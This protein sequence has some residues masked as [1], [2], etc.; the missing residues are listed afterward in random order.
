M[1]NSALNRRAETAVRSWFASSPASRR[2]RGMPLCG[3]LAALVFLPGTVMAQRF[4]VATFAVPPGWTQQEVGDALLFEMR[5]PGT[6]AFC[7]IFVRKSRKAAASLSQ[8]LDR[9]WAEWHARQAVTAETPDP[10]QLDLPGGLRLAQR[11]G[12]LQTGSGTMLTM[13]N[14]FQKADR[15]VGVVVNMSD[16]QAHER[17]SAAVGDFLAS[18]RIDTTQAASPPATSAGTTNPTGSVT[19]R[20]DPALA[21]K[22]GNSVVGT[23]RYAFGTVNVTL[24]APTQ[25]RHAIDVRF[26]SN[27]TYTIT[28]DAAFTGGAGYH[29]SESGTYQVE[30][31]RIL[32]RPKQTGGKAA[33][34][35]LDWFFGDNPNHQGN[36]GLILRCPTSEWLGSFSGTTGDWRTFK[37]VQ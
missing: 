27:G 28:V 11:V 18:L 7:Q 16:A 19:P 17:C 20:P 33:S 36:W 35:V 30:G 26:A 25:T 34:Y 23:W 8:E 32:M 4:D 9:T 12:Q 2:M 22:F 24:N 15:L 29:E 3:L 13:L 31:Q 6:R 5:P 1:D 21:A 10:A 37:P 14:L